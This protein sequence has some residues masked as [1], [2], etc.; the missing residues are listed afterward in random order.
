MPVE[1]LGLSLAAYNSLKRANINTLKELIDAYAS[2][3]LSES[4]NVG[5]KRMEEYLLTITKIPEAKELLGEG[6]GKD[7]R[8]EKYG[9]TEEIAGYPI[10]QLRISEQTYNAL[11]KAG[12]KTIGQ[13][14]DMTID[15]IK[16][17]YSIG[18]YS[19][20][21]IISALKM[22]SHIWRFQRVKWK[23]WIRLMRKWHTTFIALQMFFHLKEQAN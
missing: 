17:T 22:I 2:G 7:I 13:L 8:R 1:E 5:K 10:K 14:T 3:E 23:K 9:I 6:N 18:K 15:E 19:T 21:E 11:D 16:G 4:K 20:E 12:I